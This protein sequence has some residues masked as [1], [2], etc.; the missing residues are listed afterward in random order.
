M[1]RSESIGQAKRSGYRGAIFMQ[2][3]LILLHGFYVDYWKHR[4]PNRLYVSSYLTLVRL[5]S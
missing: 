1:M 5:K 3:G 4:I 2:V